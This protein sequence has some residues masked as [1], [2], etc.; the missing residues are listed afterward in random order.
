MTCSNETVEFLWSSVGV[1]GKK[2]VVSFESQYVRWKSEGIKSAWCFPLFRLFRTKRIRGNLDTT[3]IVSVS[4]ICFNLVN[5]QR[6]RM[7]KC[8]KYQEWKITEIGENEHSRHFWE[9]FVSIVLLWKT[10]I[11]TLKNENKIARIST[12]VT[13]YISM[14]R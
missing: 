1:G 9:F 8:I 11:S 12:L 2:G 13:I 5:L 3:V 14:I 7:W 6:E 4:G 10:K